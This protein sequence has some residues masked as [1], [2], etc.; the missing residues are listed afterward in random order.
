MVVAMLT[1]LHYR[2]RATGEGQYIDLS[3]AEAMTATLPEAMMD[4]FMNGRVQGPIGN[5][6]PE[7]APHGVF[8]CAGDDRWIAFAAVSDH[9][10]AVLCEALGAVAMVHDGRYRGMRERLE[11][12]DALERELASLTRR[13]GRDRLVALLRSRNLAAGPVYNTAEVIADPAFVAS[14]AGLRPTHKEAGERLVPGLPT[15]FSGFTPVYRG[16][17]ALGEHTNEVLGG[18]LG[19]SQGEIDRFR[20]QGVIG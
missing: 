19:Y 1:A 8:P 11:N 17:P 3:I 4:Y 5:R 6:D 18:V 9:E 14:N 12:V 16:A 10:F 7:I 15:H 13:F 20:N 2:D